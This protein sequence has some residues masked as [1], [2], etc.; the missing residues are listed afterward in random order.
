MNLRYYKLS[1]THGNGTNLIFTWVI[2]DRNSVKLK[3]L[4]RALVLRILKWPQDSRIVYSQLFCSR[5]TMF[6]SDVNRTWNFN[7]ITLN[8]IQSEWAGII[9]KTV[10]NG[11]ERRQQ[12]TLINEMKVP[13]T[14][15][16]T[17]ILKKPCS[18]FIIMKSS[19]SEYNEICSKHLR[20]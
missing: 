3:K 1:H 12:R 15:E 2:S 19:P 10:Y 4:L 20:Q 13:R 7:E 5:N 8:R 9:T 6:S 16:L 11:S 17:K 14:T 18:W